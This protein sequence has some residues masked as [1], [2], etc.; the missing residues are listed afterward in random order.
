MRHWVFTQPMSQCHNLW[1]LLITT[2]S[3]K[4]VSATPQQTNITFTINICRSVSTSTDIFV[5]TKIVILVDCWCETCSICSPLKGASE[6]SGYNG[7]K[8][9]DT[10][11]HHHHHD[12]N[13]HHHHPNH[14]NHHFHRHQGIKLI[15]N[16]GPSQNATLLSHSKV[17]LIVKIH[18][19]QP[20]VKQ[21]LP[22]A[23]FYPI[24]IERWNDQLFFLLNQPGWFFC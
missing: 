8:L 5:I 2:T 23:I 18:S 13:H 11:N 6:T 1:S 17:T 10:Y 3:P 15:H 16:D 12:P 7:S 4:Q 21:A 24:C 9:T 20:Y 22:T 19:W 14:H